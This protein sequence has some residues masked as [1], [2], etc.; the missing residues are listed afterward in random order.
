MTVDIISHI[1]PSV[2]NTTDATTS[3]SCLDLYR[4]TGRENLVRTNFTIS[5]VN[6]LYIC[7]QHLHME[8]TYLSAY[9]MSVLVT[10]ITIAGIEKKRRYD[11][12]NQ[13]P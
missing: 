4:D 11:R 9:A 12:D 13:N 8:N 1:E 3:A 2:W 10:P 5:I 7:N 6:F